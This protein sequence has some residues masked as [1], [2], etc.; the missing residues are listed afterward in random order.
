M[1]SVSLSV[2]VIH[3][4][5][6]TYK[7]TSADGSILVLTPG[8]SLFNQVIFFTWLANNSCRCYAAGMFINDM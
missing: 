6:K 8:K 3:T 1:L 5:D 4:Q 7:M 2:G